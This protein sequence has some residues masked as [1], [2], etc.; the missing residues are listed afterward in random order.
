MVKGFFL[1]LIVLA[2]VTI[3][4]GYGALRQVQ[5]W[6]WQPVVIDEPIKLHI[7]SG[8]GMI[9]VAVQLQ[10]AGLTPNAHA[11]RYYARYTNQDKSIKA[12]EYQFS[13]SVTADTILDKLVAGD[14]QQ[15][16]VT[17]PEGLTTQGFLDI[18]AAHPMFMDKPVPTFEQWRVDTEHQHLEGLLFPSTYTFTS[19]DDPLAIVQQALQQQQA[20]L[21][22]LWQERK[23]DL[24]YKTPYEALIMA[25]IIEKETALL[26][27]MP[28]IAGVFVRRLEKG[29]RLQTDPTVIYGLGDAFDGNLTRQHLRQKTAYNTYVIKGLPPTPISLA[30]ENALRAAFNPADGNEI[31]FVAKGDGSHAFSSTY[32]QHR[33]NIKKYQ[34]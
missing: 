11:L 22:Q 10:Q 21:N 9:Q 31:F 6:L 29:M 2:L 14:V 5:D 27:E 4:L 1:G 26:S 17:I 32:K 23:P 20:L 33:A 8:T 24:P 13:G 12:G 30:G 25:S 18:L 3:S 15:Y 34:L 7:K 28:T 19:T 16:T